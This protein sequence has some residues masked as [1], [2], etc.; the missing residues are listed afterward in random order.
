MDWINATFSEP[1]YR[2]ADLPTLSDPP[3]TVA[4][5]NRVVIVVKTTN[6]QLSE[7]ETLLLQNVCK[8]IQVPFEEVW[9]LH[10]GFSP[11]QHFVH[12]QR[13]F[14]PTH[15]LGFGIQ[16]TDIGLPFNLG[17]YQLLPFAGVQILLSDPL[18]IIDTQL[19][20]KKRLWGGLR[21]AFQLT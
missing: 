17:W 21:P 6:G 3:P 11:V 13:F 12:L 10:L 16:T 1:L 5:V 20:K 15:L 14:Q 18:S 4:G 8:A 7:K 2:F 9:L 19:D